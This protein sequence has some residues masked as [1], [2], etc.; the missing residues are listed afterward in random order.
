MAESRQL[1]ILVTGADGQL[2]SSIRHLSTDQKHH[3]VFTTEAELDLTSSDQITT[4]FQAQQFD[5]MINCAAYTAVDKAESDSEMAN[6]VNHLAVAQLAEV[7]KA[8]DM[9][10]I[11]I[12]TDY[13][14]DGVN[15]RPYTE[16]DRTAPQ[17]VYGDTKLKGEQAVLTTQP[18]GAIIRT[19]WVYSEFGDNFV[20]TMLKLGQERDELNVIYDQIGTP[21]YAHDLAV[22]ILAMIET[23]FEETSLYHFSNEGVCSWYDFAKQ[24]FEFSGISCQ[25]HPIETHQY[26]T[27]AKRPFY[28]VINKA[29]FK[30]EFGVDIPYWKDSLKTCLNNLEKMLQKHE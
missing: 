8:Y 21:T 18:N 13:V 14:F 27:A 22:A 3:F 29:K 16:T 28:S 15:H 6:K 2:G 9:K 10:F 24:I 20:K 11:H 30:A 12:S 25:V 5:V 7:A 23:P 17:S 4:F 1:S 19:S 26:P